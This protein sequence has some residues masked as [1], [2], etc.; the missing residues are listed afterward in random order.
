MLE[1]LFHELDDVVDRF[2]IVEST[3]THNKGIRKALLWDRLKDQA[4]F[5]VF[6]SKVVHLVLD[7]TEAFTDP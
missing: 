2:F 6:Q 3:R 5:K 7:D 1:V 4:R